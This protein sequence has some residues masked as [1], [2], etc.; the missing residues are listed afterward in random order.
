[1]KKIILTFVLLLNCLVFAIAED[2]YD[3]GDGWVTSFPL[4]IIS[5]TPRSTLAFLMQ[6]DNLRAVTAVVWY[7]G[8]TNKQQLMDLAKSITESDNLRAE[9]DLVT[10]MLINRKVFAKMRGIDP[11]MWPKY[12]TVVAKNSMIEYIPYEKRLKP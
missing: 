3:S 6:N 11:S 5:E 12:S 4:S 8:E 7:E 10:V 1:M 9:F 2:I